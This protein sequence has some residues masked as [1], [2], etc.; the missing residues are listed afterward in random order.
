[1]ENQAGHKGVDRFTQRI[2]II[3]AGAAGI[4]AA[5]TLRHKGYTNVVIFERSERVG[6]KCCS[7]EIEGRI[8]ELGAGI[9]A[10]SNKTALKLAKR[11][12]VALDR[13]TFGRSVFIDADTGKE[14]PKRSIKQN[15]KLLWQL[16]VTY[17]AMF[18]R[19]PNIAKPGF[20]N[21]DAELALPFAEFA[22]KYH[23]QELANELE[24]FFTGFG[25]G[26]F[27]DVPAAYV[28]KYYNWETVRAF[29]HR[30]VY[31]VPGGIQHLWT[32]VGKAQDVRLNTSIQRIE[33]GDSITITTESGSSEFDAL[34]IASPLDEAL[35]YLNATPEETSL[36]T[37]ME[38]VDYRTIACSVDGIT[39][40]DGYVPK[41][42][43]SNR[44]GEPVFWHHRHNDTNI[45]T[46][47]TLTAL[48]MSDDEVIDRTKHFIE[49]MGGSMTQTH[50]V[51]HWKYFPYVDQATIEAGYFDAIEAMQ[52]R[53]NTFYIGE[54]L[55]FSTVGLTSDYAE[56]TIERYF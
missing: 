24:L 52:G 22:K 56:A 6:G 46:F 3:G 45:Y 36:F 32:A 31:S 30:N 43:S 16:F 5:E 41:N 27:A 13:I 21:I 9:L 42:F 11:F 29:M 23:I 50:S 15:A 18:K 51:T 12:D 38:Y 47:Y 44:A 20:E 10:A 37:K 34:I 49:K 4:T 26:Y 25:Y 28:L 35:K 19:W 17:R 40:A 14:L 55:N 2:A 1:M 8:Y 54:L 53:K 39:K 33:R 48:T 7:P